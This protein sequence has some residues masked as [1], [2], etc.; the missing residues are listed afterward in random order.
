[1]VG[2]IGRIFNPELIKIQGIPVSSIDALVKTAGEGA[3][4]G[5]IAGPLML[6]EFP[7]STSSASAAGV[8]SVSSGDFPAAEIR[9]ILAVWVFASMQRNRGFS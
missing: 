3:P 1:M 7:V 5:V 4:D 8:K 9:G 6:I 2:I